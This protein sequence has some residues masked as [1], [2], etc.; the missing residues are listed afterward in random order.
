M[1]PAT[2]R[3]STYRRHEPEKSLLY[4][5]VAGNLETF[6]EQ[7]QTDGRGLPPHVV[8][9]M[10]A[11]TRCGILHYGFM[12]VRCGACDYEGVVAFSCKKRGWCPSC[13]G[14][15]MAE[16]VEHLNENI[17]PEV[18]YRQYVV[19]LPIPLRFWLATNKKLSSKVHS[20]IKGTL[21]RFFED[22]A[23]A[24]GI[25]DPLPGGITFIQRSGAA[26]NLNIH[27]HILAL[28]G[29]IA[30]CCGRA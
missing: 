4:K 6:I 3:S 9:E 1:Q 10:R 16:T 21:T 22:T 5:T 19:S 11:F 30:V 27:Y 29:D 15:R 18:G 17:L 24:A 23:R 26:L 13:C 25:T 28:E 14:K 12:R 7:R 2:L 8:K 20:I